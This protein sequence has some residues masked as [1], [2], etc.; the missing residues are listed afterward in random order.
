ML[1]EISFAPRR[2]FYKYT[3]NSEISLVIIGMYS[4]NYKV[5]G[6]T[7]YLFYNHGIQSKDNY[8]YQMYLAFMNLL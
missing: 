6:T 3:V 1:E 8:A 2:E 7:L 4:R 5:P